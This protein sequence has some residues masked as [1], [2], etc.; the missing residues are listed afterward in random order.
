MQE[1]DRRKLREKQYHNKR[2]SNDQRQALAPI[3]EFAKDSKI[4]FKEIILNIVKG[5]KVLELGCGKSNIFKNIVDMGGI[6]TIIDISE[7]AIE[8]TKE[9]AIQNNIQIVCE[10][11]DAENLSYNDDSFDLVFGSG[12]LHHLTIE[13]SLH[14]IKRVVKHGGKA[15]FY[16]PLGHNLFINLFRR[17]TPSLRSVDEHPLLQ[18]DLDY[19]NKLFPK[20][21]FYYFYFLSIFTIPL[22]RFPFLKS[23]VPIVYYIDKNL[24]ELFPILSRYCWVTVIDIE[25]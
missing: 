6:L 15:V 13:K 17:L 4:F 1:N 12:I 21:K 23:L 19:I 20:S 7:K 10:V 9:H 25:I 16:E 18:K 3:Y 2:Y 11:M 14:E 8:I 22:A 5:D 24:L